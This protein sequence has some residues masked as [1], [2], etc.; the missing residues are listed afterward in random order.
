MQDSETE[1]LA[2]KSRKRERGAAGGLES[3]GDMQSDN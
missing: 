1:N 2:V 3:L